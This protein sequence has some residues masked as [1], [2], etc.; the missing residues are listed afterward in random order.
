MQTEV[1]TFYELAP[2]QSLSMTLLPLENCRQCLPHSVCRFFITDV[3]QIIIAYKACANILVLAVYFQKFY[4]TSIV[5]FICSCF[6]RQNDIQTTIGSQMLLHSE[7][8]YWK[9]A[10]LYGIISVVLSILPITYWNSAIQSEGITKRS[11]TFF[12]KQ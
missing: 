8:P 1:T 6:F 3:L 9:V 12:N 10:A 2:C 7:F 11:L 5:G 4:C